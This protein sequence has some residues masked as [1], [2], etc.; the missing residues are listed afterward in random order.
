[1]NNTSVWAYSKMARLWFDKPKK[2]PLWPVF[3]KQFGRNSQFH[4]V[5][6]VP[7]KHSIQ[8]GD[9][10]WLLI[11]KKISSNSYLVTVGITAVFI[12]D[13]PQDTRLAW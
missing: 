1:M 10:F 5:Y 9:H 13:V 4:Q 12:I 2:I 3:I 6:T 11:L 8:F 7:I